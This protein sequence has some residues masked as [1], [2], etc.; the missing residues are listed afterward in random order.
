MDNPEKTIGL[1]YPAEDWNASGIG[2]NT[3]FVFFKFGLGRAVG[4]APKQ[5]Q[6]QALPLRFMGESQI[7]ESTMWRVFT[8]NQIYF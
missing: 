2:K 8:F 7:D 1:W 6:Y 4:S 5:L 3:P